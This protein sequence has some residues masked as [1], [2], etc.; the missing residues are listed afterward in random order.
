MTL[1]INFILQPDMRWKCP[2]KG[3]FFGL[4]NIISVGNRDLAH[5]LIF[6]RLVSTAAI[7]TAS[8]YTKIIVS[9]DGRDTTLADFVNYFIRP[10]IISDQITQAV[11]CIGI[12]GF[13]IFKK[14]LQGRQISMYVG[15]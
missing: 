7:I 2:K 8:A 12:T 1:L 5:F 9:C 13:K 4:N 10:D 14:S 15:K 6:F 11:N 3:P